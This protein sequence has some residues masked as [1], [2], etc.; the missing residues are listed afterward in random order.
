MTFFLKFLSRTLIGV[1]MVFSTIA[2]AADDQAAVQLRKLLDAMNN[3]QGNFVQTTYDKTGA[4][5]DVSKGNFMLMRPGKFYWETREPMP[6]LLVSNNKT[7]WL[8]DADLETVTVREFT[9]DLRETPALLLSADVEQ[10]RKQFSVT[11]DD[12]N[13]AA[14][15]YTLTPKVTEGM[16][17]HLTL[18]FKDGQLAEFSIKDS[19]GQLTRCV[20]NNTQRNKPLAEEKFF[21]QIPEGVEVLK[22]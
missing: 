11:R 8:Y 6:Q 10:L 16:F 13:K 12:K 19:L 22:D 14:E 21:F 15:A 2:N 5:Q 4:E 17:Q 20:L 3:L 7:I 9:D 1:L 18:V